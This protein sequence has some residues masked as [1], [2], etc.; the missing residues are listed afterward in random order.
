METSPFITGN[1]LKTWRK[2]SVTALFNDVFTDVP[3]TS[4]VPC[5]SRTVVNYKIRLL[6]WPQLSLVITMAVSVLWTED[7]MAGKGGKDIFSLFAS[8]RK[9]VF[10]AVPDPYPNIFRVRN[11][12]L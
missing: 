4:T 1:L 3:P 8:G 9:E 11:I 5:Q 7:I 2:Y 10:Y 12:F 6:A